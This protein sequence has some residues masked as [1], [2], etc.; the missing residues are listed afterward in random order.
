[1]L[2]DFYSN[3]NVSLMACIFLFSRH[4]NS[5]FHGSDVL[6]LSVS[7]FCSMRSYPAHVLTDELFVPLTFNFL[8]LSHID[9]TAT[10]E[11]QADLGL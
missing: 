9:S 7:L 5:K 3:F 4:S 6:R 10:F 2:K 11:F 1:M 8:V